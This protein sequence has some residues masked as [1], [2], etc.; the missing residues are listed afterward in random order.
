MST[1]LSNSKTAAM[2]VS[3]IDSHTPEGWQIV[4]LGDIA[5][6][7]NQRG[8]SVPHAEVFSVTKY[9]GFVRSLEYFDRQVFSRDTSNYKLVQRGDLAYA[10]IH[11]DEG[12]LGIFRHAVAG[13]ISPMYTVFEADKARID[14]EFLFALMKLPQMVARYRRIG[15]GSVHRRKSI[16]FDRLARLSFPIPPLPEQRAMANILDSIDY[17]IEANDALVSATEQ[18]RDSL[19]HNLLTRGLPGHHTQWKE[20]PGL[21]TIPSGW[22]V[23]LLGDLTGINSSAWDPTQES[24]ILYLDL[25]AISGP[26]R[27]SPPKETEAQYA[28]SR[29]RRR[30][31]SGDILVSTVRP[32][33]RGFAR[34]QHAPRNLV[35][36]TG[37]AVLTPK[38]D[39]DGAFVYHHVLGHTFAQHLEAS[40]TGQAYPAVRPDDVSRYQLPLPP[41]PEQRAIASL[42]D[43]IDQSIQ[44]ERESGDRLRKLKESTSDAL[45]TGRVRVAV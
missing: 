1:A 42:L 12:S 34:V 4:R 26:G 36:S 25:T 9:T 44:K 10:T 45:L 35:A 15:E 20:V 28:P 21:G 24:P 32:N 43:S 22:D 29:A 18:L 31:I 39:V 8:N 5:K 11:L 3:C 19:L 14:P 7:R 2:P 33:L 27:L 6:E 30:V 38:P 37:F 40:M 23:A 13:L 41:L 16:Q 17:A